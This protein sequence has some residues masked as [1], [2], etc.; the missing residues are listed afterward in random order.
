MVVGSYL[1]WI[2]EVLEL[3][4]RGC[5]T[6][7]ESARPERVGSCTVISHMTSFCSTERV[8]SYLWESA[9]LKIQLLFKLRESALWWRVS[10][11]EQ[12]PEIHS[13]VLLRESARLVR[14][15]SPVLYLDF[16]CYVI[17]ERVGS[18][19]RV[20]SLPL[21]PELSCIMSRTFLC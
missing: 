2:L 8:G 18:S 14:V 6:T 17:S 9:L 11:P 10:S 13:S 5:Q 7:S 21:N 12:C 16:R 15:S 4:I 1:E 3:V 20:S 19:K